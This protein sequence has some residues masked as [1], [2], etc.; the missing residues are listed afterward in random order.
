M[1]GF[2]HEVM[3]MHSRWTVAAAAASMLTAKA[4]SVWGVALTYQLAGGDPLHAALVTALALA[5]ATVCEGAALLSGHRLSRHFVGGPSL[6]S[7]VQSEARNLGNKVFMSLV[8]CVLGVFATGWILHLGA[9]VALPVLMPLT[10]GA[11][12]T[13]SL[14]LLASSVRKGAEYQ[15]EVQATI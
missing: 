4:V 8:A 14:R 10:S 9:A 1:S 3:P 11:V 13:G 15:E 6:D 12:A 7:D 5:P 2:W